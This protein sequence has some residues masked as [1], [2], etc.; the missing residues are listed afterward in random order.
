LSSSER[1]ARKKRTRGNRDA[2]PFKRRSDGK[3]VAVAY[4]PD[5]KRK[6]CYGKTSTEAAERR[7]QFYR[8]LEEG[9]PITVGKGL[10][11]GV[12][13][14]R[15]WIGGTLKQRVAAGLL[16]ESSL[17][18]YRDSCEHHII[19]DLG[20]VKLADLSPVH[21]REWHLKMLNKRS[22]RTP[23]KTLR[24]GET[25]IPEP[26]LLTPRTVAIHHGALRK[27]LTDA[28]ADELVK[29]NVAKMVSAP[30]A[31]DRASTKPAPPDKAE[32]ALLLAAAAKDRFWVYWLTVLG[33]GLRRGE[34]LGMR[35]SRMNAEDKTADLEESVQR[36]RGEVD[37]ETGRRR[38][39]LV[40]KNLKTEASATTVHIPPL[41]WEA[42]EQ[43]HAEQKEKREKAKVWVDADLVFTT[44]IGTML[45]PRNMNRAWHAV[46]DRSGIGR[47]VRIHDL[48]HAM[49]SLLFDAGVPLKVIQ[50]VLRHTRLATTADIYTH[51]FDEARRDAS[52]QMNDVLVD[53]MAKRDE[54]KVG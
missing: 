24:P 7:K 19:P 2:K 22:A 12:Y 27:A 41:V 18:T 25:T 43:H 8:E 10:T 37:E 31:K 40:A 11:L 6:P 29:R 23:R 47:R 42:L 16:A 20:H 52:D 33:L 48:R 1:P 4:Y 54:R 3:W 50:K 32:A 38:G 45:E 53:L 39:R 30:K 21:I 44:H 36:L 15:N 17:D 51:V 9:A 26:P 34:G 13:L 5:G 28:F 14:E 49:G 46:C 35:W